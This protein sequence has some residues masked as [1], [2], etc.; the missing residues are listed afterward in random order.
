M[1]EQVR[2]C[3]SG[4][5]VHVP[6][7]SQPKEPHSGSQASTRATGPQGPAAPL[8]RRGRQERGDLR[9]APEPDMHNSSPG[10]PNTSHWPWKPSAIK[11]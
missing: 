9:N 3:G 2:R 7:V 10:G 11:W 8:P 5:A 1:L 6:S 4:E